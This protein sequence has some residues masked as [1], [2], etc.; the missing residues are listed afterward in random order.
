MS[1]T[2]TAPGVYVVELPGGSRA[3]SGVSTSLTAFVGR[4]RR[5]P[6]E[7]PKRI[8]GF[9]EFDREFG[10]LWT[11]SPMSQA[12]RQYFL[13]GGSEALIVRVV[14]RGISN[15]AAPASVVLPTASSRMLLQA[16]PAVV[17]LPNFH[18]LKL[19]VT[20]QAPNFDLK[21]EACDASGSVLTDGAN[22]YSYTLTA[23]TSGAAVG[24][25]LA[26]KTTTTAPAINLATLAKDADGNP[27]TPS[28][29]PDGGVVLSQ[30][31][32]GVHYAALSTTA[33]MKL[34]A[35]A[36]AKALVGFDHLEAEVFN[37]NGLIF[38]LK[39]SVRD[40]NGAV[41]ADG[42]GSASYTISLNLAND[43]PTVTA[44]I[45]A[46]KTA[47]DHNLATLSG[48]KLAVAPTAGRYVSHDVAGTV[49]LVRGLRLGA[50]NDGAWGNG[51]RAST[52]IVDARAGSFHLTLAEV[53]RDGNVQASETYFNVSLASADARALDQ[54]LARESKLARVLGG[55]NGDPAAAGDQVALHSGSDGDPLSTNDLAGSEAGKT[56]M[57]A[58]VD[59]DLFNLLC[60][61]LEGW[62][63]VNAGELDLWAQ[64][65]ALCQ[66]KRAFLIVDP[67]NEWTSFDSAS[68]A[69]T[70][71]TIRN[72][73]A[74]MYFPRIRAADPLQ[75]GRLREFPPCGAIAG[76]MARTDSARGIWKAPAGTD[77]YLLGV[78]EL[79][80]KL[81]DMQQG[82]LN[83]LGVNCLRS[84]PVY[85]TLIWG[86]RTLAG[87]DALASEWKYLPVRRLTL[88][89]EESLQR[90]L[91]WAVFE[92]NDEPLWAQVRQTIKGFMQGL[93]RQGAFQ[94]RSAREAYFIKCDRETTTQA[95]IDRGVVNV[96][97]GFAPVRPAE[98]VVIKLQQL[99]GQAAV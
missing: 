2:Y 98:F 38:N 53:D 15:P 76:V 6:V 90:G 25:A 39:I 92:P 41:L 89:L 29:M 10:G 34:V 87:A 32:A 61:P 65:E 57:H 51:L 31:V 16:S 45:L 19:T 3:I 68:T 60:I 4:A 50:A 63:E 86:T 82:V 69:A 14:N 30:R 54:V 80:A 91:Q 95:D 36:A 94:G 77:A 84:F 56:G 59:A 1:A 12:V 64:A 5:G 74:A 62:S 20:Q 42:A 24:T 21:I 88:Y 52:S 35:S 93:F 96:V 23:L 13:N 85:G 81:S 27:S 66:R 49:A 72:A 83:Q 47:N 48:A 43:L 75:E 40:A 7:Q 99:A 67:P 97:I 22:P 70:K 17:A 18:H 44:A 73:N 58:L 79:A 8:F 55:M 46:G 9:A 26:N 37:V 78:P 71:L 33:Q 11:R 28:A